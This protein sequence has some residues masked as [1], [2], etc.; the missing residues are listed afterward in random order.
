MGIFKSLF[1]KKDNQD[2][3]QPQSTPVVNTSGQRS[4][5]SSP[6]LHM[7]GKPDEKGLYP[8]ELVM[9]HVAER[10]KVSETN[11]PG[12][13]TYQ[14]E[15]AN[16]VKALK[17]LQSRGF[18][19]VGSAYDAL[20]SYK[21]NE[22][23]EIAAAIGVTVK[24]KKADIISQLSE[25]EESKIGAFVKDR[26]WKRTAAGQAALDANPY[27]GYFLGK[28]DYNV[29]EVGVNIWTVNEEFLKNPRQSYR[30]VIYRQLNKQMNDAYIAFNKNSNSG[31]ADTYRYCECYRLMGLFIEEEGK[32]FV[33][34]ADFYFQYIFKR[35]N[36]HAGLQLL[37]S[38]QLFKNDKK[39]QSETVA[40]FYDD[41][42]LYPFHK[43]ELLRLI[44]ELE[45][46]DSMIKDTMIHSF[47]RARDFGIM[48]ESETADFIILELSGEGDKSKD[49]AIRAA[50]RAVKKIR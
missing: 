40:R 20:P 27:I 19:E 13:L 1:G 21:V 9:L 17:N 50:Q 37:K 24:G 39:Y 28:H 46:S 29:T 4:P 32:S 34:A 38:Y 3:P 30:D 14:Y 43:A 33:N 48:S 8:G 6:K 5:V 49:L 12:Y 31:N 16:P 47:K 7:R 44:D 2:A 45:V 15:I 41:I 36:I 25:I 10:Y 11:Y 42:Q 35:I 18:I 23:K 26:N 22:L